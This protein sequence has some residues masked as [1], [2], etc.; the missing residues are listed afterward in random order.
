MSDRQPQ[1]CSMS[2]HRKQQTSQT[3]VSNDTPST[4]NNET[5]LSKADD[6]V[7][8]LVDDKDAISIDKVAFI[9]DIREW[10]EAFKKASSGRRNSWLCFSC[11]YEFDIALFST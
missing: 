9:Y 4:G 10:V 5:I 8:G 1:I 6:I 7:E 3:T 11:S 2:Q